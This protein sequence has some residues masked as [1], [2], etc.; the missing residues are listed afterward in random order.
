MKKTCGG[1]DYVLVERVM[2]W[3][4]DSMCKLYKREVRLF[5]AACCEFTDEKQ[6]EERLGN[7]DW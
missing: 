7:K 2:E 1:C 5:D 3:S 4:V 6:Q